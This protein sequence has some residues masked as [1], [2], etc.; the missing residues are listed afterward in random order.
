MTSIMSSTS[1]GTATARGVESVD[2]SVF[3]VDPPPPLS[4]S[5]LAMLLSSPPRGDAGDELDDDNHCVLAC[6]HRMKPVNN[7][8]SCCVRYSETSD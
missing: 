8:K 2:T 1:N 6:S 5:S 3:D 7:D 4:P